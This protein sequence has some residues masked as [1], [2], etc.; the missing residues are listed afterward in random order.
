MLFF[1]SALNGWSQTW[2]LMDSTFF[3]S[4]YDID[5]FDEN[6]GILTRGY[7]VNTSTDGAIT[8]GP[9]IISNWNVTTVKYFNNA[10]T[11]FR[12]QDDG[13]IWRSTDGGVNWSQVGGNILGYVT[14]MAFKGSN[15]I[16]VDNYCAIAWS[17]DGGASWTNVPNTALCGNIGALTHID[18]PTGTVAYAG[19]VNNHL[20][21]S[22]DGGQ[23]WTAITTLPA[24]FDDMRGLSFVD[25]QVGFV[26]GTG[27]LLK[28]TDGGAT[29][30]DAA[31]GLIGPVT[32]VF[33]VNAN[34]VFVGSDGN[35]IFRSTDGGAS[36]TLDFT[37]P[38]CFFC[39]IHD[40]DLGG[41]TLYATYG[42]GGSDKK[43]VKLANVISGI[44]EVKSAEPLT[45]YPD[46]NDGHFTIVGG[47]RAR[48]IK[49]YDQLGEQVMEQRGMDQIDLSDAPKGL[50][51]IRMNTGTVVRTGRVIVQ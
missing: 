11:I 51:F 30:T 36:W 2:T 43:V 33:A 40:F 17:H 44:E 1:A 25:D 21:R 46:P 20:F 3:Q 12:G 14:A 13:R 32:D 24:A 4:I 37:H 42:G 45:I 9:D 48:T 19:G 27:G 41:T 34:L 49:I 22:A 10:S 38:I 26:C 39:T 47:G 29:W 50:Y 18:M 23:T 7:V 28:T 8:W 31:V 6:N 5:F 15:G 16:A 35:K